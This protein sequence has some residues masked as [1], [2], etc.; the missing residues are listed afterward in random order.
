[1]PLLWQLRRVGLAGEALFREADDRYVVE[2]RQGEVQR[3]GVRQ[4]FLW[5][6]TYEL[7]AGQIVRVQDFSSDQQAAD[8]FFWLAFPPKPEET[9]IRD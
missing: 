4:D 9:V 7:R 2:L 8:V 5:V 1:M 6:R 3:G